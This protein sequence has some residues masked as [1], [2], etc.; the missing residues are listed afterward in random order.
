VIRSNYRAALLGV[1]V[2]A[3]P[4]HAQ[5]GAE[6]EQVVERV[7]ARRIPP[8]GPG[9]TI[10]ASRSGA[11]VSAAFGFAD[12]ERRMPLTPTSI[13]EAG[14]VSKQFTAGAIVLLALDGK[15][16]LD[17]DIRR[18]FPE[19]PAY[20][21]V[22]TIRHLLTHTSGLRDWGAIASLEGWPRGTRAY[23][24][25]HVLEIAARQRALNHAPGSAY[26][27]TNTGY[28]LLALLVARVS[29]QSFADFTRDRLFLPLGM[30][31][32]SWRDDHTRLVQG[33]ALAYANAGTGFA[34][35]M[36][37]ENAHGNGGLL[38]TVRDLL[39]WND[40]MDR[41]ALGKPFA[42]SIVKR[43]V[44][45]NTRT[46]NYALG[47]N[48]V[49]TRGTL[50]INHSGSTGGYRAQLVRFP[51]ARVSVA[52]LCNGAS[53][54]AGAIAYDIADALLP[55]R[56]GQG[57]TNG[58]TRRPFAD[59]LRVDRFAGVWVHNARRTP[60]RLTAV[61]SALRRG[62]I[63]LT[64]I[65]ANR[66]ADATGQLAFSDDRNGTPTRMVV[67]SRTGD[68]TSYFRSQDW[69]PS[70]NDLRAFTGTFASTEVH[71]E[72]FRLAIE[73]EQVVLRQ[74]PTARI[75]LT[76]V[77]TDAFQA[78][79]RVVWFTRDAS[80]RATTMFIGQDRAWAVAF[81]RSAGS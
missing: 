73:G 21:H 49:R 44:L 14:S 75:G 31:N 78:G 68:S 70:T 39:V 12:L 55:A 1:A 11:T 61:G 7:A 24:N 54:N 40:A 45:T 72:P 19:L 15:L 6:I 64:P 67:I 66:F 23:T 20:E 30:S 51:D 16:S 81:Q 34:T 33:R 22:I 43:Y 60:L 27:Y 76:P 47:I 38:T 10:G 25:A 42:D 48:V 5:G 13:L 36:P 28:N 50:E 46:I 63:T 9:C 58:L 18:Y 69:R 53:L 32:T 65:G 3:A 77:Y 62:E 35:A 2:I 41:A 26:S 8:G 4:L 37:N 71:G 17:D 29:G 52:V 59:T 56:T 80:G 79:G 74:S 57:V